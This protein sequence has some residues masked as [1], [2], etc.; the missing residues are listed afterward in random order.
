MSNKFVLFFT[1]LLLIIFISSGITYYN[2]NY[3]EKKYKKNIK[4]LADDY[5][6][7]QKKHLK[8]NIE[9]VVNNII[10]KTKMKSFNNKKLKSFIIERLSK[11]RFIDNRYVFVFKQDKKTKNIKV[12]VHPN[13][14]N[15]VEKVYPLE[16]FIDKNNNYFIKNMIKKLKLNNGIFFIYKYKEP[17]SD[18][19]IDKLSYVYYLKEFDW[20][21]GTG[22]HLD[23]IEE[24]ID[25]R[26]K[27][28]ITEYKDTV[29]NFII[30]TSIITII[31]AILLFLYI[32]YIYQLQY[33]LNSYSILVKSNNLKDLELSEM[34][35]MVAHQWRHPLSHI[36]AKLID[37]YDENFD[38]DKFIKDIETS[39]E[40]LS[41]TIDDFIDLYN[42]DN[43][44]LEKFSI[45][46]AI[47]KIL[48]LFN[49]KYVNIN[50][51][52]DSYKNDIIEGNSSKFKQVLLI[53]L[54]NSLN[55]FEQNKIK[56]PEI[57]IN[58]QNI[59]KNIEIDIIDN[60]GGIDGDKLKNVFDIY[61]TT[62]DISS[63]NGLGLY[64][65][66]MIVEKSLH[67]IIKLQNQNDGVKLTIVLPKTF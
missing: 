61:Y 33:K 34:L 52:I 66:K 24:F 5:V 2:L 12:L 1:P 57:H 46:I 16:F 60:A 13:L 65:A 18:M 15:I 21:I 31:V 25:N 27:A 47:E 58:I 42:N 8:Y 9:F 64:I 22:L 45:K 43:S 67:G 50:F 11:L 55:A 62:K 40:I 35:N 41:H 51:K 28:M 44:N 38:R 54:T 6:L 14:S 23:K 4:I 63:K 7:S 17:K 36:N 20:Y 59:R 48:K 49:L 10:R 30:F 19:V 32:R 56:N 29:W 53:V 37:L 3:I 39:T 26:K